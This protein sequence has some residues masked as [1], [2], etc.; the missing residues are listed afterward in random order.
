MSILS[1]PNLWW[2]NWLCRELHHVAHPGH[3]ED[4]LV[5]LLQELPHTVPTFPSGTFRRWAP[6]TVPTFPSGTFH[7]WAPHTV[8]TFPSGTFHRWAPHT[9]P[10]FPSGTFHRWAPHTIPPSPLGISHRW[11]PHTIFPYPPSPRR[12]KVG[13]SHSSSHNFGLLQAE[14]LRDRGK[15]EEEVAHAVH[16]SQLPGE[17]YFINR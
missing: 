6:H 16:P 14:C 4:L 5:T 8:P 9:V 2:F 3:R 17:R 10:P 13:T 7:R 12:L 11:A 1:L 15:E